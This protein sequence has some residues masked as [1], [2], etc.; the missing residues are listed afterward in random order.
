MGNSPK[1]T[2]LRVLLS[3]GRAVLAVLICLSVAVT[4]LSFA[5]EALLHRDTFM[6]VTRGD[7]AFFEA[8]D[9]AIQENLE[10]KCLFYDL[11]FAR[12]KNV[13]SW[14]VLQGWMIARM[15]SIYTSLRT[16]DPPQAVTVDVKIFK[17]A[18]DEFF[19]TLPKDQRP[20]D[21]N[22]SLTLAKDLAESTQLVIQ[23]GI[24]EQLLQPAQK[25][26]AEN[27]LLNQ[28]TQMRWWL[29][30]FAVLMAAIGLIP[31]K[32]TFL[33]RCYSVTGAV[34]LG[35]ALIAVPLWLLGNYD[36]PS[37]LALGESALREYVRSVMYT[38][39]AQMQNI[40]FTALVIAAVCLVVSIM[41][42][43]TIRPRLEATTATQREAVNENENNA[44]E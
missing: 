10:A 18:I 27:G 8:V 39:T 15:E 16:G 44:Q 30:L 22:A 17:D 40:V 2:V 34:F 9:A 36:L 13:V 31:V 11:P 12:M 29:L 38:A 3:F 28:F 35:S 20:L 33:Q 6:A 5:A 19:L 21:A 41:L 14:D 26:F 32:T 7:N 1:Q 23:I 37:K 25:V 4:L 43:V 24:S 42:L